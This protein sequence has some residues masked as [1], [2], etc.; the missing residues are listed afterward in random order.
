SLIGS[1]DVRLLRPIGCAELEAQSVADCV[2]GD[3]DRLRCRRV[4]DYLFGLPGHLWQSHS[5][6]V[7]ATARTATG[8]LGAGARARA[9]RATRGIDLHRRYYAMEGASGQD[10]DDL[11]RGH[12][13]GYPRTRRQQR[14]V[15]C[16]RVRYDRRLFSNV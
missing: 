8:Q 12:P 2:D 3:G 13:F 7:R 4:D 11:L 1:N 15:Q 9:W 6:K 14:T 10:A 16:E 5:G